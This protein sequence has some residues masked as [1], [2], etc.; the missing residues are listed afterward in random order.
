MKKLIKK[1]LSPILRSYDVRI[2]RNRQDIDALYKLL[3]NQV[4][5]LDLALPLAS[6]QTIDAFGFQWSELQEGEA[7]LS[8]K[9]F[10][11][12]VTNIISEREILLKEE[13]FKGKDVIDC[14]SG[15]G[16]WSYGLAKMGAN[17]TAVDI[18]TSAIEA[19]K[20]VLKDINVQKNFILTPLE[21]LGA[22]LPAGKKY[23]LAWSWGVL[24]HC[25]GFN[26]AF[27]QVMDC[28]KEGGF[29][30]LYLY[31]R[32]SVSYNDDINLFKNRVIYNTLGSWEEK[33]RF[34]IE[35]ANGDKT[36]LHQNH[37][38]YSPLLNRRLEFDY[39]KKVLEENGFTDV[40]RTVVHT[41]L[42]I[43]AVKGK[44]NP[45]D[46]AMLLHPEN[47]TSWALKYFN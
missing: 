32:E 31:G 19:T 27:R 37:D 14:G 5:D 41:E 36:K 17:V 30:Y 18:N 24:H 39:V 26:E 15:G 16:R 7:M 12:N 1:L 25:S 33:E 6:A 20:E 23:D 9:W 35:K 29:I 34:L 8:D 42:N 10:K 40:T 46:K 11:E 45:A 3:Y 43:R 2:E 22:N 13:W 21:Q 47:N 28:V 38:I 44:M 4:H